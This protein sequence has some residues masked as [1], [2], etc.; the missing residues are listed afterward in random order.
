MNYDPTS[1]SETTP[2]TKKAPRPL[3]RGAFS[4]LLVLLLLVAPVITSCDNSS[5]QGDVDPSFSHSGNP[6]SSAAAFLQD[7]IY[8]SLLVEIQYMHGYRPTDSALNQ[9]KTF[10]KEHLIKNEI[11][12][13]DPVEIPS[14]NQDR[15]S[16]S[17]VRNIEQESRQNF[18]EGSTLASYNLF[19]DGEYTNENV[20][21]ISYYNT[22]NAYFG[23]R[24]HEVAGT[25]PLNPSRASVEATVMR[26]EYGHL[27]GLVDNGTEMIEDHRENGPHC[28]EDSCVMYFAMSRGNLFANIFDGT[29]PGLCFNC[30]EDI[31]TVKGK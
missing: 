20:L 29:T 19:L 3:R 24:I 12:I 22:S 1:S 9:L 6:G 2:A 31:A 26:H 5:V 23:K 27:I 25:P 16:A 28:S 21:G 7:E 18:T 13:L 17:D 4:L 8:T 11:I 10:L 30:I 14:G 15:Y